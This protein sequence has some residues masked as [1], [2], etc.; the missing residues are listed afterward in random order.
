M[1]MAVNLGDAYRGSGQ[2]EKAQATY[3]QAISLGYKE[4]QTNSSD[5]EVMAEMA[6]A[7]AK[8]GK[9]QEASDFIRRARAQDKNDINI[10]YTEAQI[11]ALLGK[12]NQA[13]DSLREALEKHYPADFAAVDPDLESL[14]SNPQFQN[15]IK[16]YSATK[17]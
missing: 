8:I 11:G 16:K 7:Y 2:A 10:V 14:H 4:L 6:L 12:S 17:Q 1:V 5:A 13:L 9:P 3:Q 15:L